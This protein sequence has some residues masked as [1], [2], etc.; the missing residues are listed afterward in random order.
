M[1]TESAFLAYKRTADLDSL[2][3]A[4][5]LQVPCMHTTHQRRRVSLRVALHLSGA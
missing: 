1:A 4:G 5:D 3:P 2:W